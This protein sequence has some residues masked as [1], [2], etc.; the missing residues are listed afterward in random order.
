MCF[1]RCVDL[2][3]IGTKRIKE[4]IDMLLTFAI[5]NYKGFRDRQEFNLVA[6]SGSESVEHLYEADNAL[7]INKC[8]CLVGPNGSGKTH[9]LEALETFTAAIKS[10]EYIK[11]S[12]A[13]FMLDTSSIDKPTE[14]EVLLLDVENNRYIN[15]GFSILKGNVLKEFLYFKNTKKSSKNQT[16]FVRDNENISFSAKYKSIETLVSG[17]LSKSGLI[18]NYAPSLKNDVLSHLYE[19]SKLLFLFKPNYYTKGTLKS[20]EEK[21]GSNDEHTGEKYWNRQLLKASSI[22][23]SLSIPVS[24]IYLKRDHEGKSRIFI[25]HRRNDGKAF[26]LSIDDAATFFSRGSF[27]VIIMVIFFIVTDIP[28]GNIT[29]IVDEYDGSLHHKLSL[30]VMS[31]LFKTQSDVRQTI[32]ATHD[33]LLL[34]SGFRRDSIFFVDKGN[35]FVSHITRLSDFPIRKEAKI[36]SK[37]LSSEFGALPKIISGS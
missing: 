24:K 16:L 14:Y 23:T 26:D 2:V 7:K 32:I 10:T 11:Y 1:Y 30:E 9:L 13:P 4:G 35:D 34:D 6:T 12:H 27:T 33:I 19:W 15:Y 21:L 17:T 28:S 3:L 36:S 18:A 22:L 8:A 31:L 37:Y 20:L 5:T 29:F 25:S